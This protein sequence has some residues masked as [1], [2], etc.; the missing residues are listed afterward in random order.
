[1]MLPGANCRW[2]TPAPRVG[3]VGEMP[4]LSCE[5]RR[6]VGLDMGSTSVK[7][8]ELSGNAAP[9]ALETIALVAVPD[10][11]SA[12]AYEK[13]IST[14]LESHA[15]STKRVATSVRGPH[16]A[17]RSLKFPK[18]DPKEVEG[19]VW[20]EGGQLI[21]F[22]IKDAYVDYTVM[23]DD[24]SD[25]TNVLFVAASRSEVDSKVDVLEACGLEPRVV[26]VDLLVLLE[27]LQMTTDELPETVALLNVGATSTGIGIARAGTAPFVRD[28]DIAGS[29]YTKAI[30]RALGVS[31]YEAETAKITEFERDERIRQ[32][33]NGVTR[34]LI[35]ELKRSIV[36]YQTRGHGSKI[37][38]M[39]I[40]GGGSRMPGLAASL[41]EALAIPVAHWSPLDDV[42]VDPARFDEPSVQQLSPYLALA[43]A[44]AMQQDVH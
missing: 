9:Y 1:M 13:A 20:Y 8:V 35:G 32:V 28:L 21:A 31:T 7:L 33:A 38:K 5:Q 23:D 42:H 10:S 30:S 18:L 26:G 3:L 43:T 4:L 41:S 15:P 40:C 29:A 39:F 37:E 2:R 17:V 25:R 16:V 36:Y 24:A 34:Q 44:L 27:A 12:A 11:A 6:L 22:D 19:A 14:I